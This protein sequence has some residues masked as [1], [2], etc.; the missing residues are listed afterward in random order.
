[1]VLFPRHPKR[2]VLSCPIYLRRGKYFSLRLR[3]E[4]FVFAVTGSVFNQERTFNI[5]TE[6]QT[7]L[8]AMSENNPQNMHEFVD[9]LSSHV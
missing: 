5:A 4:R 1:M 3:G 7:A 2:K 9:L 6:I 8:G